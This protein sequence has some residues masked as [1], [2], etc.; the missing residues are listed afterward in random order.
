MISYPFTAK[1]VTDVNGD[2]VYDSDGF[3]TYDRTITS[4]ME[5]AFNKSRYTNGVFSYPDDGLKI[6]PN[7]RMT[8]DLSI[9]MCNIEGAMGY[10]PTVV[11]YTLSDANASLPR[12]DRFVARFD[13]DDAIRSVEVYKKEGTFSST[14][15]APTVTTEANYYEIVLADIYVGAG[16]TEITSSNI[17]DQRLNSELCGIVAAA[18]PDEIDTTSIFDQYQDALDTWLST[19]DAAINET[20]AGQLQTNIDAVQADVDANQGDIENQIEVIQKYNVVTADTNGDF[21]CTLD[22]L[23]TLASG[24][25]VKVSFPSA[26]L[27]TADARLSIDGGINYKNIKYLTSGNNVSSILIE[28]NELELMYDGTDFII[29]KGLRATLLW[30]GTCIKGATATLSD[31]CLNYQSLLLRQN[32]LG[33]MAICPVLTSMTR[34]VGVTAYTGATNI[35]LIVARCTRNT[36]GTVITNEQCNRA[37]FTAGGNNLIF[38]DDINEIWGIK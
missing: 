10:N 28:G 35:E 2:I 18:L 32:S 20:L 13:L 25:V 21:K 6:T 27:N 37:A 23:S 38:S 15:V 11:T 12:I 3:V 24:G 16:A 36:D 5:R 22:G 7:T 33:S 14:P 1:A 31:S 26:T 17:K 9:G 34:L 19:V 4:A 30:S 29:E 8:V